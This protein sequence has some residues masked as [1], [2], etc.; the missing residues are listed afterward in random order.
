V[1]A[2]GTQRRLALV[3]ALKDGAWHSGETIAEA[4][5]VSRTAVWKHAAHLPD[6][7]L[8][9]E[10]AAGQG[11]RLP[12]PL[13][14][15]DATA[16][17]DALDTPAR[18][19]VRDV[20]VHAELASTNAHLLAVNT[21]LPGAFDLCLAEYQTAGRGRRGRAWQSPFAAGLCFSFSWAFSTLPPGLGALS[22]A[23]GVA[24]RRTLARFGLA[25]PV[26]LKWPNDLLVNSQK[27]GGIL[28]ELRAEAGGPA[29]V[30]LG[31]GLNVQ[32]PA[33]TR[34][35]VAATGLELTDLEA[36][37][38]SV[39]SAAAQAQ[40][41]GAS[42]IKPTLPTRTA[43]AAALASELH[44]MLV[45]FTAEGFAPFHA[46]WSGADALAGSEVRWQEGERERSGTACGIALDGALQVRTA[47]DRVEPIYAGEVQQVR[48][49]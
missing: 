45:Q 4:M 44:A 22:L 26:Q 39:A 40:P 42:P 8:E 20:Q 11:Y 46:E 7:G 9:L 32:V 17:R 13:S 31:I 36:V 28:L 47:H 14:L 24:V 23:T 29:Y 41:A 49:A 37:A 48:P 34:E 18:T 25:A 1:A 15:L 30:V 6:W 12:R 5:G 19:A 21:L 10:S 43:L 38:N 33:A 3:Q 16:L 35:A 2:E 27:L